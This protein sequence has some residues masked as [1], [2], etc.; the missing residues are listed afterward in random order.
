MNKTSVAGLNIN[1]ITKTDLL[2]ELTLRIKSSQKTF[3]TTPYSEFLYAALRDRGVLE[4]LNKADIAVPDG[5]GIFW[6]AKFLQI[7]LTAKSYFGKLLQALWQ[8]FW[9]L[10]SIIF[11]PSYVRSVLP[12]KISGSNLIFDLAVLA[13]KNNWSI[14]LLGGYD[15]T[16]AIAAQKLKTYILTTYNLQLSISGTSNKNPDDPA[17]INDIAQAAPDILFV[18]YGPIKQEKWIA[19][20]IANLPV[21]LAVGLGGTF[22][23]LAEKVANPPQIL[24]QAGLEWLFRLFT[25]PRRYKRIYNA[26]FGLITVI[27]KYKIH[28]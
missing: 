17:V 9:T 13:A 26:F 6:A 16:P 7:P 27:I 15:N 12:E 18:A 10:G 1:A 24:R 4:L 19:E 23:Y 8:S 5:I 3:L 28:R 14:Y 22:D 11:R 25:Q 21:K 2:N 20:N